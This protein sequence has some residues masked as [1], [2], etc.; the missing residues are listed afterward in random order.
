MVEILGFLDRYGAILLFGVI[1][2]EPLFPPLPSVPFILASGA[3]VG[4]GKMS[5]A[6]SIWIIM[7]AILLGDLLS[8][9]LG[10]RFGSGILSFFCK[11]TKEP[12]SCIRCTEEVFQRYGARYL[13]VSKFLPG[14][15]PLM[16][17]LAG[18]SGVGLLSFL[19]YDA[20]GTLLYGGLYLGLGYFLGDHLEWVL[21]N[22]LKIGQTTGGILAL[23]I[24]GV[25]GYKFF[26]RRAALGRSQQSGSIVSE[27]K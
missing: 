20:V 10:R 27:P 21:V 26:Q 5:W 9:F 4:M 2:L 22:V 12:D 11:I 7:T 16:Y 3:L 23:T 15:S 14:I 25:V 6:Q 13:T 18:L 17:P 8:F 19:F 24:I 1:F